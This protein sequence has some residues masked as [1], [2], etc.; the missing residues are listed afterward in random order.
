MMSLICCDEDFSFD[1]KDVA[2]VDEQNAIFIIDF[3]TVLSME[4]QFLE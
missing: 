1:E 3:D 2:T 4:A